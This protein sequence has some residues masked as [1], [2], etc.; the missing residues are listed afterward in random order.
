MTLQRWPGN[1]EIASSAAF[2]GREPKQHVVIRAEQDY[3]RLLS[4]YLALARDEHGHDVALAMVG[5]DMERAHATLQG[6]TAQP[7]TRK[8]AV[9]GRSGR[10]MMEQGS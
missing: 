1:A 9:P 6:L 2:A 8:P 4:A 7:S 3:R 10:R 5:A